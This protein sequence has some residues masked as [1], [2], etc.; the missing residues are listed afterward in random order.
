LGDQD[1]KKNKTCR[2]KNKSPMIKLEYQPCPSTQI[3]EVSKEKT[4]NKGDEIM[5]ETQMSH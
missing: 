2:Q 4:F 5:K 3:T 1:G